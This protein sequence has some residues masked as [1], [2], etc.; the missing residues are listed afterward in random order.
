MCRACAKEKTELNQWF[1]F[2]KGCS[3]ALSGRL[4]R[5]V[6]AASDKRAGLRNQLKRI[7]A[8]GAQPGTLR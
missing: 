8:F 2:P 4:Y 6:S 5:A 1:G 7:R 3:D